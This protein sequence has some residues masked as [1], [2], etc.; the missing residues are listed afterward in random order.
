M[1]GMDGLWDPPDP[2]CGAGYSWA[3][4]AMLTCACDVSRTPNL[5]CSMDTVTFLKDNQGLLSFRN[6]SQAAWWLGSCLPQENRLVK[7]NPTS[8]YRK[9]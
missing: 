7:G 3:G 5:H 8:L 6:S 1:W 9:A 2:H 4:A